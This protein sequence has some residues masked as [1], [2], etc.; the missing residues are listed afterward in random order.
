M[1]NRSVAI[2]LTLAIG[3]ILVQTVPFARAGGLGDFNGDGSVDAVDYAEFPS[4]LG[5]PGGGLGAGCDSFNFDGDLDVDVFDFA[6]FQL[7]F[8]TTQEVVIEA[9]TIGNPSNAG[10]Q[11]RLQ[12]GDPTFYGGVAYTY[13]IGKYEVTAGQYVTFLN[14]VAATDTYNL[15]HTRMDYDADPTRIGCNIKRAGESGSYTYSVA[16][17][18]ANRPVNY[19]SWADAVR[20]VNWLHNGQ[21]TGTQNLS[22]TE[23]GSYFINGIHENSDNHLEDVVREPDATWILPTDSEWYKAAYHKNDG[24]TG[25]YWNYGTSSDPKPDNDLI[26]PDPGNNATHFRNIGDYTIGAPYN[27][28]EVGTHENSASPYGTFDQAGNVMEFTETVPESDIRRIHDGAW[29]T[30]GGMAVFDIDDVMHSSDQFDNL[31]FRVALIP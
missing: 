21:P 7:A 3:L 31:G 2:F 29:D 1:R 15:Y 16:F 5:G 8:G 20:F 17:D 19:V 23:D 18:W 4:C 26:D 9:V 22:T 10:E 14:A 28:T 25:N 11:S 6:G 24:V 12:N 27:R 30:A 13:N